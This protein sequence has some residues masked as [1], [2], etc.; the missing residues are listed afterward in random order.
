MLTDIESGDDIASITAA[1]LRSANAVGR[2]PTPVDDLVRA[3]GLRV[4]TQSLL[5]DAAIRQAPNHLRAAMLRLKS[6]V[7]ALLDRREREIHVAPEVDLESQRAF[8][9]L[10]EVT[11]H[12]LPWQ[13]ALAY[14]DDALTLSPS[15]RTLFEQEAN[16]GAAELLFQRELF[17][18]LARDY[19][20]GLA[21]VVDLSMRFGASIHASFRRYVE[22]HPHAVAG[23]VLSPQQGTGGTG[24]IRRYELLRSASWTERF[25]DIRRWPSELDSESM[26]FIREAMIAS[27]P[28]RDPHF[29]V[30][31]FDRS[32]APVELIGE[33][34]SNTYR[35]FVLVRVPRKLFFKRRCKI[36]A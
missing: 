18:Q 19:Q 3:A 31:L 8:K 25:D 24:R 30:R 29:S 6:K 23:L 36:A 15:T 32:G 33:S 13:D 9:K 26:P 11:H 35:V 1:L 22:T 20:P 5:Q 21:V 16:Q 28:G 17:T 27:L 2:L 12:I 4:A 10:H 7:K 14:A 34:F